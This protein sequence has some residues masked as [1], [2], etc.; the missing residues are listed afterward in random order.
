[1]SY[2]QSNLDLP[3]IG[4]YVAL[5]ILLVLDENYEEC[6]VQFLRILRAL[7]QALTKW[8]PAKQSVSL[9][10]YGCICTPN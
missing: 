10:L 2:S 7:V 6:A 5:Q 8:Y 4:I 3:V 9:L 1:M